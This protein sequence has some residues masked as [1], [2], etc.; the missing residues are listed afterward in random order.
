MRAVSRS[1]P[2]RFILLSAALSLCSLVS[3]GCAS[4][5]TGPVP[6]D[7][8]HGYWQ[9][10]LNHHAITM[11]L[12][13]PYDT[14]QLTATLSTATG[15]LLNDSGVTTWTTSD[16]SVQVSST[17]LVT[18]IAQATEVTLTA[19]HTIGTITNTDTAIINVND[20]V[21]VPQFAALSLQP[22]TAPLD[23][24]RRDL[25][26]AWIFTASALDPTGTL[27]PNVVFRVMSA[28]PTV[29][30]TFSPDYI[31][32]ST[33]YYFKQRAGHAR[34][35][36]EATV[37]G[38]RRVDTLPVTVGWWRNILV[39]V[40]PTVPAGNR[41]V[42]GVFAPQEDTVAA[43]GTVIWQ[44]TL[45]GL[46]IDILFEDSAVPQPVDSASFLDGLAVNSFALIVHTE[47][48]GNIPAFRA[49]S[50][51]QGGLNPNGSCGLWLFTVHARRFPVAGT[52]RYHSGLYGTS[53]VI[54]VLPEF[55]VP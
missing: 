15:T 54:H 52:Y 4:D 25:F 20:T 33:G 6:V 16:T 48:G 24:V 30:S 9:L 39:D 53:G 44:N 38:V 37:Y 40:R 50:V 43:G 26:G 11:A 35:V 28:T 42:V 27:I 49:D 7:S 45:P 10:M 17:G 21:S 31:Q 47:G 18:A 41:T 12:T 13:P 5:T 46:P 19:R 3:L 1:A 32:G 34:M 2:M 14:L 55:Q 22:N 23:T 29:L 8:A 51:C 36:A